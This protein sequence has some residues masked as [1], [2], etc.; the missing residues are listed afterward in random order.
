MGLIISILVGAL[1]G[2][3]AS[4]IMKTDAQQGAILNIVVGIVGSALGSWLFGS[5]LGVDAAASAGSFSLAG[6]TFGILGAVALIWLLKLVK[7]FK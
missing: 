3:L 6:L 2:W 7:V 1:I 4:K 5:L